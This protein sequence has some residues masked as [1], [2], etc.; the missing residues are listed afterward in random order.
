MRASETHPTCILSLRFTVFVLRLLTS[1]ASSSPTASAA[2]P[3]QPPLV[4]AVAAVIPMRRLTD[5]TTLELRFFFG[6]LRLGLAPFVPAGCAALSASPGQ[7]RGW[8][9]V[10]SGN[11]EPVNGPCKR[12]LAGGSSGNNELQAHVVPN[13]LCQQAS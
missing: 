1:G 9:L 4:L 12:H 7:S 3:M 5:P 6:Q 2:F 11:L 13:T 8:L 10:K